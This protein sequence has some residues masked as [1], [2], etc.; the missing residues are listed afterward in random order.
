MIRRIWDGLRR[1]RG[2][3]AY[4]S[5]DARGGGRAPAVTAW[6]DSGLVDLDYYAAVRG[7]SFADEAAAARDLVRHGMPARLSPH[8]RIDFVSLPPEIRTH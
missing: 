8:P 4:E 7:R 1:P 2:A 6:L 3:T 5:P